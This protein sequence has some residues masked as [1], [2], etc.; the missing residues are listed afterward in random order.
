LD[1]KILKARKT[2]AIDLSSTDANQNRAGV[3]R[4][5]PHGKKPN[6]SWVLPWTGRNPAK[7]NIKEKDSPAGK[8]NRSAKKGNK[9]K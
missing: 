3:V 9:A 6:F 2:L 1:A 8:G 4:N 7:L 5:Q